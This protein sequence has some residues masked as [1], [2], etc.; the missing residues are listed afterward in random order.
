MREAAQRVP[1]WWNGTGRAWGI[2]LGAGIRT[3]LCS[4]GLVGVLRVAPVTAPSAFRRGLR[5]RPQERGE[6]EVV[7]R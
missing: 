2:R 6:A 1:V 3:A 7:P 5:P 4:G